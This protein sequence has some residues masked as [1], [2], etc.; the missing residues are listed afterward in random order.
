MANNEVTYKQLRDGTWGLAGLNLVSGTTVV[1]HKRSGETKQE[2]VGVSVWRGADGFGYATIATGQAA[3][4]PQ[5]KV[6]H[7]ARKA[8]TSRNTRR[9][10]K[11]EGT[12]EGA[13]SSS[14]E[15]DDG[16]EVGRVCYLKSRGERIPVVVI[17]WETGYCREDG[18]SFG[19]PM[20]EGYFTTS[21]YRD[22]T[23]AEA[24]ELAAKESSV[25]SAKEAVEKAAKDSKEAAAKAA[26][27]PLEG[28]TRSDSLA[29]PSGARTS[30]GRY[31]NSYGA[32]V[33]ITRIELSDGKVVYWENSYQHDDDRDYIWATEEVLASLYE[34]R[35]AE[36]PISLEKAQEYLAKYADCHGAS[37]YKYVVTK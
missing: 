16:D 34:E 21:S 29:I 33:S 28:L 37:I 11:K 12:L 20:D 6:T 25:K 15:G 31:K 4:A 24:A 13:Y 26:R 36:S 23:E 30:L 32:T 18:L 27:A 19:L 10:G 1:V 3:P 9:A 8:S 5:A 35:L 7:K 17:G 14:R 2:V 22:A